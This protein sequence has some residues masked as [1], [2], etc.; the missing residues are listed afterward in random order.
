[1]TTDPIAQQ[2]QHDAEIEVLRR[3]AA[4]LERELNE[5]RGELYRRIAERGSTT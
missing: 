3:R 4:E 5:T 2:A 1:M